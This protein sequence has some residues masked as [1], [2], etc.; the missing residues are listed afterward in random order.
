MSEHEG[1]CVPLVEAMM[2]DVPVIAYN[3]TAIPWTL[4]GSGILLDDKDPVLVAGCID[5]LVKDNNLKQQVIQ[6]QRERLKD[7][8]YEKIAIM[9]KEYLN[10]FINGQKK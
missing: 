10:A 9:F 5:K 7:F 4:N 8:E 6:K 1:F 2:F 3:S